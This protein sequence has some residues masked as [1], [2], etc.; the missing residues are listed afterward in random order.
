MMMTK[1]PYDY[2][3]ENKNAMILAK[4]GIIMH[5]E[6]HRD[7]SGK[8]VVTPILVNAEIEGY[9]KLR[10]KTIIQQQIDNYTPGT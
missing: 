10:E 9:K 1:T 5:A 7:D 8:E 2:L 4:N 6:P 3:S